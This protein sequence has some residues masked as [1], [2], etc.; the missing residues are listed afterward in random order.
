MIQR[1]QVT[2]AIKPPKY[3]LIIN[4]CC[5]VWFCLCTS[6]QCVSIYCV[7][8]GGGGEEGISGCHSSSV[9]Y[10]RCAGISVRHTL[11]GRAGAEVPERRVEAPQC[12]CMCSSPYVGEGATWGRTL[13]RPLSEEQWE[14]PV[15]QESWLWSGIGEE[16][17]GRKDEYRR[18]F[19]GVTC[20]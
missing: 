19:R 17:E 1:C 14:V 3:S 18:D 6:A 10:V 13:Q 5:L 8:G 2:S 12:M 16:M 4:I 9:L 7:C 11:D 15:W 20:R